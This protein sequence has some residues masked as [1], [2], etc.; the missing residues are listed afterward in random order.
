MT[1]ERFAAL[2]RS[3]API[4]RDAGSGG[5][6]RYAWSAAD[7]AAREWFVEEALDRDL[8]VE[9]DGNG[10]IWAWIGSPDAGDA[11]VTGSHLDSV[12][13]GGAYDGPLGVVSALLAIDL[14]RERGLRPR[15]PIAV[16]VFAEEEGSRFGVP[17]LGS[18]LMT[19]AYDP[20]RA[21][22]LRDRDG[23]RLAD[24][25]VAAD[26]DPSAVG[27][28]PDRLG[29]IGTFVELHVEQGRALADGDRPVGVATAIWPHG[30]WRLT[31]TG[32]GNHAGT[33]AM[34]DRHDPML[35]VAYAV[36]AAN[37]E[38]RLRGAR[39]TIGRMAV[40]PNATNAIPAGVSAWLDARAAEESTLD[41]LIAAVGKRVEERALRDGTAATWTPE[42]L[43][44]VVNFDDDLRR[45]L[46]RLLGNAPVLPTGAGHDAGVLAAHVPTAMLFVRNPSGVS[47][48]PGEFASDVDC[49]A[50]VTALADVLADLACR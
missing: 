37:K 28:D 11:V 33:T 2:W 8:S 45:R 7:L 21:L 5:Y 1:P 32:E 23:V 41:D 10:N 15:R 25:L 36:L 48:A 35:T 44:P 13:H 40:E 9:T 18:R 29:R 22:D 17:C 47:H 34:A 49:A 39:A 14:L 27:P 46:V 38:A 6:V 30:R 20:A 19:G 24:A 50:G 43:T 42:S 12:P 4:G 26:A 31:V 3:L 16:V